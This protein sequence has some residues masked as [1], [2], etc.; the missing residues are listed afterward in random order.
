MTAQPRSEFGLYKKLQLAVL[1][2]L[3]PPEDFDRET[4]KR[5]LAKQAALQRG[6]APLAKGLVDGFGAPLQPT[7]QNDKRQD[8]WILV[9]HTPRSITAV[10]DLEPVPFLRDGE[11]VLRGYDMMGR[12]RYEFGADLGQEDA[13]FMLERQAEIPEGFHQHYLVFSRTVWLDSFGRMDVPYLI[14]GGGRWILCFDWLGGDFG[15]HARLA[16]FRK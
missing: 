4:L 7:L 6:L 16:R 5:L 1:D 11:K 9:D 13:E 10:S 15:P 2:Q 3:P 8:G 14:F 12:A